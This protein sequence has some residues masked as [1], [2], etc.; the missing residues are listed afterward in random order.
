MPGMEAKPL[1]QMK[2]IYPNAC[3][4]AS[5]Q[6]VLE[7]IVQQG[8]YDV[9]AIMETW[10]DDFHNWSAKM[11]GYKLFRRDCQGRRD[12]GVALYVLKLMMIMKMTKLGQK[13]L[14]AIVQQGSYDVVAIMETWWDDFHNWSAT[15]D[16]YK[17]FR[18]DCQSRRDGGVALYV[19]GVL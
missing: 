12:G 8:S 6:K 9:V 17:L 18:R 5:K 15:M 3:S 7:A 2:C 16:G 4:M 11:D 10:W 19:K 14:E 1:A 13:V